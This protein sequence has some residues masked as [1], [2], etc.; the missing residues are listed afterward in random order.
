LG[1]RHHFIHMR[2]CLTTERMMHLL[3]F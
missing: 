1:A 2:H 3:S